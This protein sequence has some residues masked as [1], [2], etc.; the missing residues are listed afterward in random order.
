MNHES[1]AS[2]RSVSMAAEMSVD[3]V[4]ECRSLLG[5]GVTWDASS[6]TLLWVDIDGCLLHRLHSNGQHEQVS[7]IAPTS[8]VVPTRSGELL[9]VSGLQ[10][11]TLSDS[12]VI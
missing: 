9:A 8:V 2:I 1:Q 12:G 4:V 10:V 3:L 7:M 5:E 6:Q 11:G